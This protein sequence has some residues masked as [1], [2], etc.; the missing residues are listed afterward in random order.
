[1]RIIHYKN[2]IRYLRVLENG[3][4]PLPRTGLV[5]GLVKSPQMIPEI[6]FSIKL[7]ITHHARNFQPALEQ[8]RLSILFFDLFLPVHFGLLYH[9]GLI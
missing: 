5:R 9:F 2:G 8:L 4:A 1:M 7:F 6:L 3:C